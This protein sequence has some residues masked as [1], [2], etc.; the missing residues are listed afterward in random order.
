ML[1][2]QYFDRDVAKALRQSALSNPGDRV[3]HVLLFDYADANSQQLE[4]DQDLEICC[5][6]DRWHTMMT[7]QSICG[8]GVSREH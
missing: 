2:P 1:T 3:E 7:C 5:C 6:T 8:L 4:S